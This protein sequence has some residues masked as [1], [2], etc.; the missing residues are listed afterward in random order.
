MES[1]EPV[2]IQRR[3]VLNEG[4]NSSDVAEIVPV[5]PVHSKQAARAFALLLFFSF[6]MFSIP[7]AVYFGTKYALSAYFHINGY[8]NMVWSVVATVISVNIIIGLYVYIA[9]HEQEY[10][11]EGNPLKDDLNVDY[12]KSSLNLKTD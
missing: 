3:D 2:L 12:S 10:D 8:E 7:F 4:N 1:S 9:Y 5:L 11:A 6:L